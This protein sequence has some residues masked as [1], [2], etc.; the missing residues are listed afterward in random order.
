MN[1]KWNNQFKLPFILAMLFLLSCNGSQMK[2]NKYLGKLPSMAAEFEKN[3]DA[4]EKE[5]KASKDLEEA[6]KLDKE[7]KELKEKARKE[8]VL[9]M[10]AYDFPAIPI[11]DLESNPFTTT[12][13][14][15]NNASK[16]RV[17]LKGKVKIEKDLKNKYGGYEKSFFAYIKAVDENGEI[18]G[19]PTV[20]ASDMS[21]RGPFK[22]GSQV[23]M[24]G[25]IGPLAQL[26]NLD[27]IEFISKEEYQQNK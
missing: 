18:I 25:S 3:I 22:K 14:K 24:F 5:I 11:K 17:N 7:F 10:N 4:L 26:V 23:E 13:L 16:S 12:E 8:I 21:N 19:K 27:R 20:M 15:V 9:Y 6:F 1:A 2:E